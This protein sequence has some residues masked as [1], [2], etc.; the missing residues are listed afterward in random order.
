[1]NMSECHSTA[2][3]AVIFYM[4][5]VH[6]ICVTYLCCELHNALHNI[7]SSGAIRAGKRTIT[8]MCSEKTDN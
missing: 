5:L 7:G 2:L 3:L 1:M 6:V 8:G 4:L